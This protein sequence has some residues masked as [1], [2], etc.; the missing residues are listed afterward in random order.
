MIQ[1]G[2]VYIFG[3]DSGLYRPDVSKRH[4]TCSHGQ[5]NTRILFLLQASAYIAVVIRTT[6]IFL[7]QFC[8]FRLRAQFCNCL[9]V[10]VYKYAVGLTVFDSMQFHNKHLLM[11]NTPLLETKYKSTCETTITKITKDLMLLYLE[12]RKKVRLL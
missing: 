9:E 3:R 4:T 10:F 6:A 12:K 8:C 11:K 7:V 1:L 2:F 5:P